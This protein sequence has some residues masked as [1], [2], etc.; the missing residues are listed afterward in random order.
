MKICLFS[1]KPYWQK[2]F[3]NVNSEY[4]I[5][6][7]TQPLNIN[8]VKETKG[9]Q[10]VCCFVNDD[11]NKDVI[12]KLSENG[13]KV[14][15]MR[16]AGFNK[17]DLETASKLEI[18][19]LRVPTYSP[20]AVSEYAL[21]LMLTLNRKT[22]KAYSRVKEGN[23]EINGLEGFNMSNKI[24]GI[25]G[26]GNIGYHLIRVL[27]LG[28]NAKVFAYDIYKS[29]ECIE[30]GVEYVDSV[31]EIWKKCDIIS[32]HTP[33][34]PETKYLINKESLAKM[35]DGVMIINVSRGALINTRD[36]INALK[37][38][39]IGY[40]GLDTYEHEEEYFFQDHSD[41]IIKDENLQLLVSFPN[42]IVSSHQAWYT[43][44]AISAICSTTIQNL[45]DYE[46]GEIKKSNLVNKPQQ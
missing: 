34:N 40:L 27:R 36:A 5:D 43:K 15:L 12:K 31:D 9:Y 42:V 17:V 19:V 24:F 33:L 20:N 41:Q 16:C 18:P 2:W 14:I 29:K 30:L 8:T 46:K 25:I 10:A 22:H 38:G 28:F 35:K 7:F 13:V 26:T 4:K 11:L 23:F 32:L 39:K 37:T 21:S 1:S 45:S 6:Y 44:E 3:G